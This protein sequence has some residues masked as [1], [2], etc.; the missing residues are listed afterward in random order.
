M[1]V[2][3]PPEVQAEHARIGQEYNRQTSIRHHQQNKDLTM[4][5]YLRDQALEALP[6]H[7]QAHAKTPDYALFPQGRSAPS[8]TPPI[9]DFNAEQYMEKEQ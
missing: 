1:K 3:F 9:R 8:Y 4:K 2:Q 5:I 7:L 6:E